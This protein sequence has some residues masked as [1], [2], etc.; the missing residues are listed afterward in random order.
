MQ[1]DIADSN[2]ASDDYSYE[3]ASLRF[4]EAR[5]A[6]RALWHWQEVDTAARS[7]E[8]TGRDALAD[9]PFFADTFSLADSFLADSAPQD[10]RAHTP[11]D[12]AQAPF[13][14]F[15]AREDI[16]SSSPTPPPAFEGTPD[17]AHVTVDAPPSALVDL[18]C[19]SAALPTSNI[20]GA[21]LTAGDTES[22]DSSISLSAG[23]IKPRAQASSA[24]NTAR[25]E[26][27][28]EQGILGDVLEDFS[29]A[30]TFLAR[31]RPSSP[32]H[33]ASARRQLRA[34]TRPTRACQRLLLVCHRYSTALSVSHRRASF[35]S[36]SRIASHL[37]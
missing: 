16:P 18:E 14:I 19:G 8:D 7:Q 13:A 23:A 10:Q 15:F 6:S 36:R 34:R 17:T 27:A 24:V 25:R 33:P 12:T 32:S 2:A 35:F 5:E 22:L 37:F 20:A 1:Y 3:A 4:Q 30:D 11:V 31:P 29:L 21:L 9:T 26:S 28:P